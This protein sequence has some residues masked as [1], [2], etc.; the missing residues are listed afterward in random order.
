MTVEQMFIT[1]DKFYKDLGLES[2]EMSYNETLGAIIHKPTDRV[3]T[4]HASVR[5]F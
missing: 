2:N 1:A 4:C 5:N 3:I